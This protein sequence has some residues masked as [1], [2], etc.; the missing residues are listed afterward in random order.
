MLLS[1]RDDCITAAASVIQNSDP[2][3]LLPRDRAILRIGYWGDPGSHERE[4]AL[5]RTVP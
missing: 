5:G 3:I 1:T 2:A 4:H